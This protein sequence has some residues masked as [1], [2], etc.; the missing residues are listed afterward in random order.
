[1]WDDG[2]ID[3]SNLK[4]L[5]LP[6]NSALITFLL[7]RYIRNTKKPIPVSYTFDCD[8]LSELFDNDRSDY[9]LD[10]IQQYLCGDDSF[11]D[12]DFYYT[13]E[14]SDYMSDDIDEAN[15]KL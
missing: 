10:Y 5:G 3:F 8:D 2:G 12:Y 14:W 15:W 9:N 4:L 1:M 7:K 11:W 13:N 6:T